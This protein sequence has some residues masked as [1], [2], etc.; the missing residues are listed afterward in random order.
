MLRKLVIMLVRSQILQLL[1][2]CLRIRLPLRMILGGSFTLTLCF[3][4]GSASKK[5]LLESRTTLSRWLLFENLWRR[6]ERVKMVMQRSTRKSVSI[7]SIL[8]PDTILI[9]GKILAKR[10]EENHVITEHQGIM[11]NTMRGK[12]VISTLRD[13]G[14]T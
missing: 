2:R 9:R 11:T 6:R 12:V 14:L 5:L 13:E 1:V 7:V 8:H 3:S 4:S 10:L